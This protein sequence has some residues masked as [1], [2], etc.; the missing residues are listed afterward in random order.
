MVNYNHTLVGIARSYLD[1]ESGGARPQIKLLEHLMGEDPVAYD[2]N[3]PDHSPL[4]TIVGE[5]NA[6]LLSTPIV[7]RT[8]DPAS[9]L[10]FTEKMSAVIPPEFFGKYCDRLRMLSHQHADNVRRGRSYTL[11][12]IS[13]M[14]TYLGQD[15]INEEEAVK[16]SGALNSMGYKTDG[17]MFIP[18]ALTEFVTGR[19]G[20]IYGLEQPLVA[21]WNG[22]GRRER[23]ETHADKLRLMNGI[24]AVTLEM[25]RESGVDLFNTPN[26]NGKFLY[27]DEYIS[28]GWSNAGEYM[29]SPSELLE[30]SKQTVSRAGRYLM[31]SGVSTA[32][33]RAVYKSKRNGK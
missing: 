28:S 20:A 30:I 23:V 31:F 17:K 14:P 10:D 9:Y 11:R 27:E 25:A 18:Q 7:A 8:L 22:R 26:A 19:V 4:R 21:H 12:R 1:M 16:I 29:P 32:I 5:S 2:P 24:M 6:N 15:P 13:G 33:E 3:A